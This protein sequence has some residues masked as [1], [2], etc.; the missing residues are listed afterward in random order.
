MFPL[1]PSIMKGF[2][3]DDLFAQA[4]IC[5]ADCYFAAEVIGVSPGDFILWNSTVKDF[6]RLAAQETNYE[7]EVLGQE[8]IRT[9]C[10]DMREHRPCRRC[11]SVEDPIDFGIIARKGRVV[12]GYFVRDKGKKGNLNKL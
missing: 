3:I 11:T 10:V 7:I 2:F 8:G 6:R 4:R 5:D 1:K 9:L 12:D